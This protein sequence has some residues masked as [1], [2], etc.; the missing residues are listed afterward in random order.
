MLCLGIDTSNYATS[1][2]VYDG[3]GSRIAAFE[4]LML[5]VKQGQLGLRQSDAV[6]EHTRQLPAMIKQLFCEL[7]TKQIGCVGVSTRPR[8]AEGSYMPC[9]LAGVS[10]ASVIASAL[11]VPLYEFSHQQ[12]HVAAALYGTP[13][14]NEKELEFFAFHVSGG[15]TDALLCKLCAGELSIEQLATS[16]DLHAGQVIDRLGNMLGMSFPSGEQVSG[17]AKESENKDFARP[18]IKD[19]DCCLSGLE[20][21]C[22]DLLAKGQ[23]ANDVCAYC[24]RTIAQT[25]LEMTQ[26]MRSGREELPVVFSGGVM[27]SE[28][29]RKII[30]ACEQNVY[31]CD[32]PYLSADNALGTAILAF[33]AM[34]TR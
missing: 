22:R 18:C 24:L 5:P 27:C 21:K 16:R 6:F 29:I 26:I 31:F 15:T 25:I 28:Y 3:D 10:A 4:K 11:G 34:E 14:R 1:G 12:G 32:P 20:N 17:A 19:G 2:A 23:S 30:M 33:R 7:D 13:L 8:T 9:F